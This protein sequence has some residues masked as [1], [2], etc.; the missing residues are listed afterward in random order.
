MAL[1]GL[2]TFGQEKKLA[3]DESLINKIEPRILDSLFVK[4]LNNRIDL[5]LQSGLHYIEMN[6]YGYRIKNLN[7][8]D[9]YKFLTTDELIDL[10]I[11]EKRTINVLRV[12]HKIISKDTVDINFGYIGF[13]GKR[14]LHFYKGIH[15]KKAEITVGCGG[16]N[17]YE[18]DIRFAFDSLT[19][20]W[21]IIKNKFILTNEN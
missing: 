14:K 12:V 21:K 2:L 4:A 18:P 1:F 17:G 19:N 6:E 11:W 3:E 20:D 9:R 10:S 16:I 5:L 7:V 8:P 15:F 13:T